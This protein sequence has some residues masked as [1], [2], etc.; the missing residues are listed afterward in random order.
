[1]VL[2]AGSPLEY[3]GSERYFATSGREG[4]SESCAY[5]KS[6]FR[7][8]PLIGLILLLAARVAA[9]Q[10]AP[11]FDG[12]TLDGWTM[13]DG[14][15]I[16]HGWEVVDGMV[17]LKKEEK[18]AGHI[19]TKRS[20]GDFR[21][22]FEWAIAAGGNSGLK[23]RVRKFDKGMLGCEY[24]I[25]DDEQRKLAPRQSAASLYALYEPNEEKHLMPVGEFNSAQIIVQGNTIEHW[26]NGRKVLTATVGD[27]DWDQRIAESKF[28][29]AKGFGRNRFGKIMLTDHGS[30]VWYRNI[31]L[32]VLPVDDLQGDTALTIGEREFI[33]AVGR[34]CPVVRLW[35]Q[36][37]APDEPKQIGLE[38]FTT[39]DEKR[40]RTGLLRISSVTKPSIVIMTP[41]ADKNTGAALVLCPGGGY[42]SLGAQTVKETAEWLNERGIAVVL[43][44]YRVPKRHNGYAMNHQPLQDAQ[45]ALGIL[46][47]RAAEWKIDPSK[48]GIGGF[49][50]GGHA[51]ASLA[52]NHQQRT[53]EPVDEFDKVSCR[54][55]FAVL[56]Y[57]AYLTDPILSRDRDAK[58]HYDR[59]AKGVTPPT[60]IAI[61]RPDKFT[62]GSI[63]YYLALMEGNVPAELHVYPEGGHG[64]AIEKYPFGQWAQEC[65]RFLGDQGI[66]DAAEPPRPL[67]Y[68]AKALPDV[69]PN[70]DLTLGDSRLRQILGRNCPVVPV[71][72]A[73][74]EPDETFDAKDEVV[75][76]RSRGGNALNI[77][78]VTRPTLTIVSPAKGK[79]TGKAVIVC[80]GGAYS[81]LA[82]EHEGTKVCEWLNELGITG[83]LLKYRVPRRAGEFLKHHHAL[84]DLQRSIRMVRERAE[85]WGIDPDKLGVCGFS[86][87]GHLCTSLC[88]NFAK[89]SY[90]PIDAIDKQNARPDFA[91]LIYPAYL[92][93]P[94]NSNDVAPLFSSLKRNVTPPMFMAAARNDRLSRGMLN[95]FLDVR[96]AG[97]PAE[98]H[99]YAAG[100]HG[101]GI[102]P[103]SYPT[104]QWPQAGARWMNDIEAEFEQRKEQAKKR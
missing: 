97:I 57:P 35:P 3:V 48:I 36:G 60:L 39:V 9:D 64:G 85:E 79:A 52:I 68:K 80:P 71:W 41:P 11:L 15:P 7:R 93:E 66:I 75:T 4:H 29:K 37:K 55:D 92:T 63:E 40:D 5:R 94:S 1:M 10:P 81:G 82:A 91:L 51:A 22:S 99:V 78:E 59:I 16:T 50:A 33:K 12:K 90:A 20:F 19:V 38:Q 25:Y 70:A 34:D 46:R 44:K 84:Q 95:F 101:G 49:S 32:D 89:D 26:L 28:S 86:A 76:A 6:R 54:P 31:K 67:T 61:T 102:D 77:R 62:I 24:Q 100:G 87:G 58:L 74:K 69:Q 43:L 83:I 103:I 45:R 42:G 96:A 14:K 30:E 21:L 88:T 56:L 47:A 8:C 13:S 98:C 17:H 2:D 18:R 104:S 53:Y 27:D 72:P 23:Y 73:G 65:Y